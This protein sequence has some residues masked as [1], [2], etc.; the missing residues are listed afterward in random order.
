MVSFIRYRYGVNTICVR[1][2]PYI[3][4]IYLTYM[5]NI[6]SEESEDINVQI[7]FI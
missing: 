5:G 4:E 6:P 7:L 2:I 3:L 1:Y